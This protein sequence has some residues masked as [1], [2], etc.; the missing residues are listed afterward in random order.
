[1][2]DT[3]RVFVDGRGLD[4]PSGSTALDA[5]RAASSEAASAVVAG[6]RAITDSRGLPL[7]PATPLSAGSI[8]RLV[9]ARAPAGD[10]AGPQPAVEGDERDADE[11]L[12]H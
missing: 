8:L 9:T 10:S 6:R 5:V 2:S 11:D 12:L 7:S 4:V 3:I 1:V